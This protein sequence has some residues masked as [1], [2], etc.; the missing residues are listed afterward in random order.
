MKD[1]RKDSVKA[2]FASKSFAEASEPGKAVSEKRDSSI[3]PEYMLSLRDGLMSSNPNIR[4][5]SANALGDAKDP[6]A[7]DILLAAI[8]D[9]NEFVRASVISS[10]GRI[11]AE[12]SLPFILDKQED[13]SEEVRYALARFSHETALEC[14]KDLANND[15][16]SQ[17]KRAARA[18]LDKK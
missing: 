8:D 7:V 12:K 14:L 4:G 10:L 1:G 15:M 16:S 17:V 5:S 2:K 13:H 11:A 9:E 18:A 6:R 3:L